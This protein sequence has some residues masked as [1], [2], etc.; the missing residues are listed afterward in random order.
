MTSGGIMLKL[1]DMPENDMLVAE[2][3]G[4]NVCAFRQVEA[5]ISW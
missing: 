1:T 3:G 5:S 4:V 2:A